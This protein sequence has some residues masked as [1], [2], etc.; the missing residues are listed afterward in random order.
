MADRLKAASR[1][2]QGGIVLVA[3]V[4]VATSNT[5]WVPAALASLFVSFVPS[6]LKR[7]LRLVL[8]VWLNFWI[9]LALFLH[10]SGGFLG[11]YDYLPGFD[12]LTHAMSA[13]LIAALGFIVVVAL[14]EYVDSIYLPRPFLG[15]FIVVFTVAIGV[16]WE[17]LEFAND[18]LT[19]SNLQYSLSDSMIDLLFD[20]LGG[21]IVAAAGSH[22]ITHHVTREQ[23]VD[24]LQFDEAKEKISQALDRR[25]ENR[26]GQE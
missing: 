8:P 18:Q 24:S 22:Y 15:F 2:M 25:K 4:G 10:V 6:I 16:T 26:P 11:F 14:D 20:S 17:L 7:D 19:G 13:S 9:V 1:G 23:F 12:H 3:F 21:L 5:T